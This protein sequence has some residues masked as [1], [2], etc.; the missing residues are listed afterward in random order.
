M[1]SENC[2][3]IQ[4]ILGMMNATSWLILPTAQVQKYHIHST[5]LIVNDVCNFWGHP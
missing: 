3:S 2:S 5:W 4:S 1:L